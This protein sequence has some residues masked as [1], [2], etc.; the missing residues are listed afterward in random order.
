LTSRFRHEMHTNSCSAFDFSG[1]LAHTRAHG[2]VGLD[3][4]RLT[5][6]G[7][8]RSL[9]RGRPRDCGA[10]TVLHFC[11]NLLSFRIRS[12]ALTSRFRHEM[13]TNSCSAFDF[14]GTLAHT[15]ALEGASIADV[16]GTVAQGPC[17]T[18]ARICCLSKV[19]HVCILFPFIV[20]I[21]LSPDKDLARSLFRLSR[22]HCVV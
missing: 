12:N 9:D 13:H 7:S 6:C 14:S 4:M 5:G 15:R 8:R 22:T 3:P 19:T 20:R 1:T 2:P 18:F 11:P 16:P 21:V 10:G 17:C